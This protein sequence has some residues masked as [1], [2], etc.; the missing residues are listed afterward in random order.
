ML[1]CLTE[2]L[3]TIHLYI[4]RSA[5]RS[6]SRDRS[7]HPHTAPEPEVVS[8]I[9]TAPRKRCK[10][11]IIQQGTHLINF[12][13]NICSSP[14]RGELKII[15]RSSISTASLYERFLLSMVPKEQWVCPLATAT[16]TNTL[17]Y[18]SRIL[19]PPKWHYPNMAIAMSLLSLPLLLYIA[20]GRA[21]SY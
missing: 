11:C 14:D 9:I 6:E 8:I 5:E 17:D 16:I 7:H 12:N 10:R 1:Y 20:D 3:S 19:Q 2:I 21:G 13:L 18:I 15:H 4:C